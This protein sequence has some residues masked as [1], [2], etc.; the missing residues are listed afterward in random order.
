VTGLLTALQYADSAFPGGNVAFSNGME[1]LLALSDRLDREALASAVAAVV[2]HRWAVADRVALAH[3]YRAG[4]D[5]AAVAT[6]DKA[7]EAATLPEPLRAGSKRNGEALLATHLR[8]GT[9]GA[10]ELRSWIDAGKALGHL[11]IVQGFVWRAS[12][13][14]E[15]QAIAV[16]GYS[17]AAGL[18]AAAVRLGK[19][20]AIGAQTVLASALAV[21]AKE[22][23][24][25]ITPDAPIASFTPWIDVAVA[26]H[27]RA[28]VRLFAN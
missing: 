1:G 14:S 17:N 15:Q 8:L 12:G 10:G 16:S 9:P 2:R 28:H 5:L 3:A 25:G 13:L 22:S 6:V 4:D 27:A 21:V 26:R 7:M 18:V 20:G 23:M 24:V 11:S 19:L